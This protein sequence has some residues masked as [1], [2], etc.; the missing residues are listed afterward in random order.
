M[1][2]LKEY[3]KLIFNKFFGPKYIK[4]GSCKQCGVCCRNITLRIGDDFISTE[5]QFELAKKHEKYYENYLMTEKDER[6]IMLFACK[7][8]TKSNKCGAYWRRSLYCRTYPFIK[9]DFIAAG[10]T[11]LDG[12]GYYFKPSDDFKDILEQSKD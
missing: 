8:L 11:T 6:G 1:F 3:F 12:C 2:L 4:A 9:T 5:K 10:G 7:F